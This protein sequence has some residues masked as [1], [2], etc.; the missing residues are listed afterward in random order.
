M[1]IRNI[2]CSTLAS[3]AL[4]VPMS[5]SA[6]PSWPLVYEGNIYVEKGLNDVC[7]ARVTFTP[8]TAKLEVWDPTDPLDADLIC[9]SFSFDPSD[10]FSYDYDHPVPPDTQGDLVIYGVGAVTTLTPGV[11]RAN[12]HARKGGGK[13]NIA[14]Q[15]LPYISGTPLDCKVEGELDFIP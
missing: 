11:C 12:L 8:T 7:S 10:E 1:F 4:I 6:Q 14:L 5:V 13:L 9:N 15:T 2:L 3:A